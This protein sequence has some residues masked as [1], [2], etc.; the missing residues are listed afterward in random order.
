MREVKYL[1]FLDDENILRV[2]FQLERGLIV[3]FVVQLE[4][5]LE[6]QAWTPI[7]R[8]DT[9]HG[10]A[11]RDKMHPYRDTEKT[12]IHVRNFKEGLTFS[13]TDLEN[14]WRYYRRRYEEWLKK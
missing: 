1:R 13:I 10:F 5:N 14:N 7:I 3:S 12:E 4:C 11:H 8:Y 2:R 6:A 9:A